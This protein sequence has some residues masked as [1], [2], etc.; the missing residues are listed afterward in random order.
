[1]KSIGVKMHIKGKT[2]EYKYIDDIGCSKVINNG[3]G[4]IYWRARGPGLD[5]NSIQ[6]SEYTFNNLDDFIVYV[7]MKN[8]LRDIEYNEKKHSFD[9]GFAC[10]RHWLEVDGQEI[11]QTDGADIYMVDE[12]VDDLIKTLK[13]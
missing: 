8:H 9:Y 2:L 6:C 7:K 11:S 4:I 1:M 5:Y 10:G 3:D 13:G 12:I